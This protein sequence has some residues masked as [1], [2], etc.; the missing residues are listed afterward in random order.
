MFEPLLL[1][2]HMPLLEVNQGSTTVRKRKDGLGEDRDVLSRY[3]TK[4]KLFYEKE[5]ETK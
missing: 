4:D 1:E 2:T 3:K 5:R